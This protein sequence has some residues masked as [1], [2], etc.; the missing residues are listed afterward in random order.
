MVGRKKQS[1]QEPNTDAEPA[2]IDAR[3]TRPKPSAKN[4]QFTYD[5]CMRR[6][7]FMISLVSL[8]IAE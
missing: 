4:A 1:V 8:D 5:D 7:C 2:M 6:Q 3:L